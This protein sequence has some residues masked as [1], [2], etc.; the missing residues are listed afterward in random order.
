[1]SFNILLWGVENGQLVALTK[2][3]LDNEDRL[4]EWIAHDVS[5][6]GLSVLIIGRQVRTP[7]GGRIDLLAIDQQGDIVI[8][9]LKRD[10]TP[11]EVVAQALDYASWVAGLLPM[12]IEEIAQD[13]LKKPLLEAFQERFGTFLPE[14]VNNDHRIVIV[15]S[16]LDDSSE[17]IVQYLSTR[18]S[19]SIN[20]VFFTCF[21]QGK[22]EF[23]GRAWLLDPEELE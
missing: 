1:M 21:Q 13:Y 16:E 10:R 17:R 7:S 15:A 2:E 5:L 22:K 23:V 8:L 3:P 12:Q 11:R 14:V 9:E 18:H 4:E 6:L 19:L 20:V